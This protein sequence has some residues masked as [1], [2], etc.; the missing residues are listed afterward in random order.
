MTA[1]IMTKSAMPPSVS[2]NSYRLPLD[3]PQI[4]RAAQKL[5]A[6]YLSGNMSQQDMCEAIKLYRLLTRVDRY[7]FNI[8]GERELPVTTLRPYRPDDAQRPSSQHSGMPEMEVRAGFVWRVQELAE[9]ITF[10]A[11]LSEFC[12]RG[13]DI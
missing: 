2:G 11:D 9:N 8:L 4:E 5:E 10:A 12:V 1:Q 3:H 7:F 13:D 6:A